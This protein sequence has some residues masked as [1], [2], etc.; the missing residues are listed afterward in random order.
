MK[1]C[2]HQ[3]NGIIERLMGG[4]EWYTNISIPQW[5]GLLDESGVIEQYANECDERYGLVH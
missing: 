1:I 3:E 5:N 2:I 4:M